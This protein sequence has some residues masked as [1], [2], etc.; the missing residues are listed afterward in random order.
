[1]C[2]KKS[3]TVS[4]KSKPGA[5]SGSALKPNPTLF[6]CVEERLSQSKFAITKRTLKQWVQGHHKPS[7]TAKQ[8]L[9]TTERHPEVILEVAA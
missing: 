7:G 9:K 8:L 1:M 6:S 3:W 4:G 5:E 2:G